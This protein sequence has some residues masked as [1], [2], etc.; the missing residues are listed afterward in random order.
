[1]IDHPAEPGAAVLWPGV[2]TEPFGTAIHQPPNE[3]RA[4]AARHAVT[5][6]RKLGGLLGF[7]A[8]QDR[9]RNGLGKSV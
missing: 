4:M 3:V 2:E 9:A 1:M 6:A 7:Q 8:R 5:G